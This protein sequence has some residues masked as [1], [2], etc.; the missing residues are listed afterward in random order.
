MTEPRPVFLSYTA[1]KRYERCGYL[2]FAHREKIAGVVVD[3]KPFLAGRAVHDAFEPWLNTLGQPPALVERTG[4]SWL[5]NEAAMVADGALR[6]RPGERDASYAQAIT[7]A[8]RLETMVRSTSLLSMHLEAEERHSVQLEHGINMYAQ[9]DI[10]ATPIGQPVRIVVELKTGKTYD[11]DQA[12]WYAA[13]L[14]Q[15]FI[16]QGQQPP[17]FAALPLRPWVDLSVEPLTISPAAMDAQVA[18]VVAIARAMR[19]D[20]W[21][22]EPG[23]YCG[24]CEARTTCPYYA[25]TFGHVGR[26]KVGI[27]AG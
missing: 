9:P 22:A 5:A 23:S 25:K 19:A 11:P 26:G 3:Q 16:I 24:V 13:A 17:V 15:E 20:H 6:W 1:A 4:P 21:P 18:R 12:V 7:V 27:S 8:G 10:V 2:Q 14:R